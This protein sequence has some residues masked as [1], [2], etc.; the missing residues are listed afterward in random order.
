MVERNDPARAG[1]KA[2]RLVGLLT[3]VLAVVSLLEIQGTYYGEMTAILGLFGIDWFPVS[4]LFWWNALLTIIARYTLGYVTG[5]LIGV[6]YDWLDHPSCSVLIGG[7]LGIGIVDGFVATVDTR[8]I[9]IGGG[10]LL[11]WVCYAPTFLWLFDADAGDDRSG[12]LRLGD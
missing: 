3:G 4:A 6:L 5:S 1:V 11:A 2:G 10:Y 8:S 12:P 7:V 9:L